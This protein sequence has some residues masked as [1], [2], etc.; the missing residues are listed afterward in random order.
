MQPLQ[1]SCSSVHDVAV[2]Q[3][4]GLGGL[5]PNL[6]SVQLLL[7]ALK[8]PC[9]SGMEHKYQAAVSQSQQCHR[10]LQVPVPPQAAQQESKRRGKV[11]PFPSVQE[12]QIK[13]ICAVQK[14]MK[15]S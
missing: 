9:S 8:S 6:G 12:V 11:R 13:E 15:Q 1:G 14:E 5:F 2:C 4:V 3:Q 10:I 7:S